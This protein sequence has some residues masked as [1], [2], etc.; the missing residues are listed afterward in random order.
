VME[1]KELKNMVHGIMQEIVSIAGK[2]SIALPE[3]IIQKSIDKAGNFPY[4]A[5]TSFQ[6][7]VESWPKPN[8]G[9]LYGGTI[10][11]AGKA[12]S[13]PTPVTEKVYSHILETCREE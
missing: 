8:E 13:I 12:Y 6:R 5:R 11:R 1:N 9:D 3:D 10:I 7:D 4:E 2:K